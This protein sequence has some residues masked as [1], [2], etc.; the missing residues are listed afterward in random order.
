MRLDRDVQ[1]QILN[2]L[3]DDFPTSVAFIAMRVLLRSPQDDEAR[4]IG[5]NALY[6]EGH[7]LV[8]RV[9]LPGASEG[10]WKITSKGMDFLEQD[11][12]L[13][14][15]LG[16]VTVRLH[17]DTLRAI[18]ESRIQESDAPAPE[19]SRMLAK[20]KEVPA[21][22]LK[23]LV[24]KGFEEGVKRLPDLWGSVVSMLS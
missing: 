11:G 17:D 21:D 18:I 8:E 12:G 1:L 3:R 10:N 16:V 4:H 14:A 2:A 15:I 20:L 13:G 6:L 22:A 19:K 24:M 9:R 23:S 7:G 5:A